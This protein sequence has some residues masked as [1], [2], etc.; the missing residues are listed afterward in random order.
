MNYRMKLSCFLGL[1][2][3]A[4]FSMKAQTIEEYEAN[5]TR[6]IT[7]EVINGVY[8]PADLEDA[9]SELERLS[10]PAGIARFKKAPEEEI[11][12]RLHFGL[13]RWI[14]INWGLEDGSR[15]SHFLKGKG[16]SVPDDMVRMIIVGWHRHLHGKPLGL[17][18]EIALVKQRMAEEKIKR[19][20]NKTVISIEKRPHK[21]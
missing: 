12:R 3:L 10:E 8:I 21:E 6:R 19:D 4:S 5:Y 2:L 20:A 1:V 7:L 15:I 9:F 11:R 18:E 17:E 14:L 13:G 16:F